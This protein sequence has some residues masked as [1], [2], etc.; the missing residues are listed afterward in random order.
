VT[1][2][3][4]SLQD[5]AGKLTDPQD[6]E[7][8]AALISYFRSLPAQDELF[9]LAQLLGFLSL[10]SQRLPHAV[11]EALTEFRAQAKTSREYQVA[12]EE[13]LA[14]LPQEIASGVDVDRMT[15]TMGESFRQQLTAVGLE[16]TVTLL[17]S[18]V[19]NVSTLSCDISAAATLL[20]QD[21]KAVSAT[22][23]TELAILSAASRQLREHNAR[24]IVQERWNAWLWQ[25][26]LA[27]L[28][29]VAGG[30]CGA[31]LERRGVSDAH[32]VERSRTTERQAGGSARLKEEVKHLE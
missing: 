16:N 19:Q 3:L 11:G 26:L 17:R 9:H 24:L 32:R 5:L 8:Y 13:R 15:Q 18:S 22:I 4:D 10:L 31:A 20:A 21:Y 29:F 7:T 28:L 27:L 14:R 30:F 2:T 25:V 23:S 1:G 6:R 12:V